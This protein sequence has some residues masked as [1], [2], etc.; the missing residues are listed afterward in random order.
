MPLVP[1][2]RRGEVLETVAYR[3]LPSKYPP[4]EQARQEAGRH[5]RNLAACSSLAPSAETSMPPSLSCK[6][7]FPHNC[8]SPGWS[9]VSTANEYEACPGVHLGSVP[10]SWENVHTFCLVPSTT[11]F[12]PRSCCHTC[13]C[14]RC[15]F[16][17]YAVHSPDVLIREMLV[18][19]QSRNLLLEYTATI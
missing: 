12:K 18:F 9:D 1:G 4:V 17:L 11:P 3:Y 13:I 19:L 16:H 8:R 14:S 2:Q 7:P 5:S 6:T 10:Y 15:S